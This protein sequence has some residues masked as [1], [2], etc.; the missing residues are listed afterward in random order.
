MTFGIDFG[1]ILVALRYYFQDCS[2]L[3]LKE[4]S[5]TFLMDCVWNLASRGRETGSRFAPWSGRRCCYRFCCRCNVWKQ[6]KKSPAIWMNVQFLTRSIWE[7]GIFGNVF[8]CVWWVV[9]YELLFWLFLCDPVSFSVYLNLESNDTLIFINC[10]F[11]F[12]YMYVFIYMWYRKWLPW[13][14]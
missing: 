5:L 9:S 11:M 2:Q 12:L 10:L 8:W 6:F 13:F 14:D 4:F 7:E 3:L 1:T